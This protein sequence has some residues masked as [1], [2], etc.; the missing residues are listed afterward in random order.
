[1]LQLSLLAPRG[2]GRSLE[3]LDP[4]CAGQVGRSSFVSGEV[5]H[6]PNLHPGEP[7]SRGWGKGINRCFLGRA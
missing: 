1:M 6:L 5:L 4:I 3:M 2:E 7:W